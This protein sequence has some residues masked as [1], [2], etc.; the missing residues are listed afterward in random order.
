MGF[1]R[2]EAKVA[3]KTSMRLT[4]PSVMLV[5]LVY[6]LLTTILTLVLLNLLYNPMT[7]FIIH[8][9]YRNYR[10][11]ETMAYILQTHFAGVV[12]FSLLYLL[13]RLYTS[14]MDVGYTSY[15]LRM[16]R[17][18]QPGFI[19]LFDGFA[20][21]GRVLWMNILVWMFTTLWSIL[22]VLPA[23]F[24]VFGM[25]YLD[26]NVNTFSTVYTLLVMAGV[27]VII[28]ITLRYRLAAYFLIDDPSCTALESIRR[29][30]E[31]MRGWKMELFTLDISFIGWY[32]LS[33]FT[34]GALLIW[35]LPYRQAAEA[36]FYDCVT[37][38]PPSTGNYVGP[39]YDYRNPDGPQN[40]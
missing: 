20:K 40:F 17:G 37:A 2:M 16:A 3:A 18:E 27:A 21:L 22:A 5:T 8:V 34:M 11:E 1:N 28:A 32:Y 31:A 30:K 7:D 9:E 19:N 24:V 39:D 25:L 10:V 6:L 15:G 35:L 26:W 38:T 12:I 14:V 33:V 4:R 36:N 13:L 23:S 29:S